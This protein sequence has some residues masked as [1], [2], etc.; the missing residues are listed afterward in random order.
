MEQAE[1]HPEETGRQPSSL[2]PSE[3]IQDPAAYLAAVAS[4]PQSHEALR[5][6]AGSV[7]LWFQTP[8]S[9]QAASQVASF[10][11]QAAA[12]QLRFENSDNSAM[13]MAG[14]GRRMEDIEM[15][16]NQQKYEVIEV[17]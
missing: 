17:R 6:L 15:L 2:L 9:A 13:A 3:F 8:A 1:A 5:R 14:L 12:T 10:Y 7:A 11:L 16:H 4:E